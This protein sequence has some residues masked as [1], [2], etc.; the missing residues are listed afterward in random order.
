MS[1]DNQIYAAVAVS[2]GLVAI[3]FFRPFKNSVTFVVA[4]FYFFFAF[5]PVINY[6]RDEPIYAGIVVE[7]IPQSGLLF[8]LAL[9]GL[10]LSTALVRQRS[11]FEMT[12][13]FASTP[14][15]VMLPIIYML[16]TAI[17]VAVILTSGISLAALSKR[18]KIDAVGSEIHYGLLLVHLIVLSTYLLLPATSAGKRPYFILLGVYALYCAVTHER[19]ILFLG[20]TILL[21]HS[22]IH[23][24][25]VSLRSVIAGA[26]SIWTASF[27]F[28]WRSGGGYPILTDVLN[29]GS[30]LFAD[31]RVLYLVPESI[32]HFGGS[33]YVNAITSL[34]PGTFYQSNFSTSSW[35]VEQ[36]GASANSGYGFSL[37]AEAYLNYGYW[38]VPIV[39]VLVGSIQRC[40]VNRIDRHPVFAYQSVFFT[41]SL[42]YSIRND[43]LTLLKANVYAAG[44]FLVLHGMAKLAERHGPKVESHI[45]QP[46]LIGD[47]E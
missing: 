32:S 43:M 47:T 19:D 9:A 14:Q 34:L 37:E 39:F 5:G 7:R 25:I 15:Y 4:C 6:L 36:Y 8:T 35:L 16:V 27:L 12:A 1:Q 31:S 33:T 18:D 11:S 29:E 41:V 44:F 10:A 24:K 30:L 40:L 28:N 20:I 3:T 13:M 46:R 23:G 21:M 2:A 42:M 22:L 17:T 45:G 38:A 26:V